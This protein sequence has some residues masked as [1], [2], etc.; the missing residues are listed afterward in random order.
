MS[1]TPPLPVWTCT[2]F[3]GHWPVG[4][5]AAVVAETAERAAHLLNVELNI[6]G[7]EQYRPMTAD[8]MVPMQSDES[9]RIL[10]DGN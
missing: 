1:D 4:V 9:V 7:P 2:K 6:R 3:L 8:D 5:A 10:C